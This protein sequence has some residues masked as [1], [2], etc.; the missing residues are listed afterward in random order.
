MCLRRSSRKTSMV[1]SPVEWRW[2]MS[3][4]LLS[5]FIRS[6]SDGCQRASTNWSC[7]NRVEI[8]FVSIRMKKTVTT[9]EAGLDDD[10][11]SLGRILATETCGHG[12]TGWTEAI[13]VDNF[14]DETIYAC[15]CQ[16]TSWPSRSLYWRQKRCR[17]RNISGETEGLAMF[18]SRSYCCLFR[19]TEQNTGENST[20]CQDWLP[21]RA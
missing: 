13:S 16:G 10:S 4:M 3:S 1:V 12:L 7:R 17:T 8:C 15:V 14:F 9:S 6:M 2:N 18:F 21:L 11:L 5:K 20:E 19:S